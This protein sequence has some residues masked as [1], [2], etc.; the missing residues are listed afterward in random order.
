M[1]FEGTANQ[2]EWRYMHGHAKIADMANIHSEKLKFKQG[3]DK[4]AS[5]E[6]SQQRVSASQLV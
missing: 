2:R 4:R 3:K 5:N 6:E 1:R